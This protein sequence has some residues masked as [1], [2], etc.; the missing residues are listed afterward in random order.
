VCVCVY[1]GVPNYVTVCHMPD[2][3]L[4]DIHTYLDL[5]TLIKLLLVSGCRVVI[6][7]FLFWSVFDVWK[8]GKVTVALPVKVADFMQS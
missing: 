8:C 4:S 2:L 7:I 5:R 1:T 3:L 6:E